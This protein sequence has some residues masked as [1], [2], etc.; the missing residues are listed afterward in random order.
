MKAQ[1]GSRRIPLPSFFNLNK[2]RPLYTQ[3]K[4]PVPN[5]H[6]TGGPQGRSGLVWKIF[7]SPGFDLRTTQPVASRCIDYAIPA[8]VEKNQC[9]NFL[10]EYIQRN[11]RWCKR[12]Y[13]MIN[14]SKFSSRHGW[15]G[16]GVGVEFTLSCISK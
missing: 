7:P 14:F 15:T 13:N 2:T 6:E 3:E 8:H 4:D 16:G 1:M 12:R 10:H 11:V 9:L 5:L